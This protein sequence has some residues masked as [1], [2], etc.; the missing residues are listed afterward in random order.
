MH[1]IF[2]CWLI[3]SNLS[4]VFFFKQKRRKCRKL[5]NCSSK[6]FRPR[7]LSTLLLCI[8]NYKIYKLSNGTAPEWNTKTCT[9]K[10]S[11]KYKNKRDTKTCI[12]HQ[13]NT[14]TCVNIKEIQ[15]QIANSNFED[16]MHFPDTYFLF[17][18]IYIFKIISCSKVVEYLAKMNQHY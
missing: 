8:E 9:Y 10:T 11:M 7:G 12:K 15:K 17:N 4:S 5:K 2:S 13:W 18:Y 1:R 3:L 6:E 16:E 14:K